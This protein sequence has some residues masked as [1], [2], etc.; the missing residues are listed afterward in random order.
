[1]LCKQRKLPPDQYKIL[2]LRGERVTQLANSIALKR[3]LGLELCEAFLLSNLV[4]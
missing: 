2:L 3:L 1:L 4:Q